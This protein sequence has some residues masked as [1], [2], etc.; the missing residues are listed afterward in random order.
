MSVH[1]NSLFKLGNE[2]AKINFPEE[3]Q[4]LQCPV[5]F[6]VGRNEAHDT[7]IRRNERTKLIRHC[8]KTLE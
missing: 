6:F 8:E 5:Y 4:S 2:A 3:V 7:N 1:P